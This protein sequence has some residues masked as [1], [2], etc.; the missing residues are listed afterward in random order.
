[1]NLIKDSYLDEFLFGTS[2]IPLDKVRPGLHEL[3]AGNCFYCQR[4]LRNS[5]VDHF[6]P[7]S[8]Y[9][10]NGIENLALACVGCNNS[11]RNYLAAAKHVERWSRRFDRE[12]DEAVMLGEIAEAIVWE[13]H[14]A[15]TLSVARA[16][17]WR[18]PR[19]ALLWVNPRDAVPA[20]R[21]LAQ[22][23]EVLAEPV[24]ETEP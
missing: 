16:L 10:D 23:R 24:R 15:R 19:D 13:R 12:S 5:Q 2:R 7:W 8:R 1:M 4:S 11:K 18:L 20:S 14:P 17:Y 3:Q 22:I 6:I 21:D 9:A